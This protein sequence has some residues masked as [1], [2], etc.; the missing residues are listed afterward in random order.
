MTAFGARATAVSIRSRRRGREKRISESSF[1][2]ASSFQS[3][4]DAEAGRNARPA[5]GQSTASSFN[6]LPTQR[7]GETR[8]GFETRGGSSCFN[9][10]P[11][12]RPGETRVGSRDQ[13]CSSCFNPLP[14]QRPGETGLS[15]WPAF[16]RSFNPLP[17]QRPGETRSQVGLQRRTVGF[18]PLPTQR[19][20]ETTELA[21]LA[22]APDVSI[23][24]RRRGREKLDR[25][26]AVQVVQVFQSAPD[27]EAG[28]NS[29]SDMTG[30]RPMTF[31]SAPDAEAG[32]NVGASAHTRA[33]SRFN[34]LPTQRPGETPPL[35]RLHL[36]R[37]V[38]IRSRRRGRE[39]HQTIA[40]RDF[41][42]EVS[43]R[44]RRRGREKLAVSPGAV[45]NE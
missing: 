25:A 43:I 42:L 26:V 6:P 19:P 27:A 23:R 36:P 9:P 31:Q 11:T 14:T 8:P 10:L 32:R 18:N 2:S 21:S 16:P 33:S 3:A 35:R 22:G 40:D 37:V 44:S 20:G 45:A 1:S 39:K 12:Q 28:R 5:I 13:V 15:A 34:P 4:P 7:P 24:S 41:T 38:S 30:A 29:M 17:T